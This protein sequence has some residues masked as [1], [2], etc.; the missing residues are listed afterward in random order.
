MDKVKCEH[1]VLDED[2][3]ERICELMGRV[4]CIGYATCKDY[5]EQ[6]D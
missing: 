4:F 3:G 1:L 6:E 2:S 5:K